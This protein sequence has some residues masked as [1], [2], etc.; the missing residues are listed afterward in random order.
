V[1]DHVIAALR[2]LE[3]QAV[4]HFVP[5][6]GSPMAARLGC[7][8]VTLPI[9]DD[10]SSRLVRLP[11]YFGMTRGEQERVIAGVMSAL[12]DVPSRE[13]VPATAG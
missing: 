6:H 4:F 5:L 13:L 8:D 9:T 3:I 12:A 7:G 10:L 11:C 1:R 2:D